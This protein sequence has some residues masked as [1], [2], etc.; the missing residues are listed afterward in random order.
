MLL[1]YFFYFLLISINAQSTV[2][3][4]T[5]KPRIFNGCENYERTPEITVEFPPK[6]RL[7]R[8]PWVKDFRNVKLFSSEA[9]TYNWIWLKELRIKS[10]NTTFAEFL[11][12]LEKN[13]C[14]FIP[15]GESVKDV[16]LGSIKETSPLKIEGESTCNAFEVNLLRK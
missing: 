4:N 11:N 2:S 8:R 6:F 10:L 3:P 16:F 7:F 12:L 15:Y 14:L 1:L 9:L 5:T 13:N